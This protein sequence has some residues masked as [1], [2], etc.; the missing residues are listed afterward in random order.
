MRPYAESADAHVRRL[1]SRIERELAVSRPA[2]PQI[3]WDTILGELRDALEGV[4]RTTGRAVHLR[5]RPIR[6]RGGG[7]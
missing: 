4:E 7:R 1:Q 3:P 6:L 5:D 2:L